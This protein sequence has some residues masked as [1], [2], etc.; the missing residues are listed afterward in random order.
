MP[1]WTTQAAY[2]ENL[3]PIIRP[4]YK[5]SV[6]KMKAHMKTIMKTRYTRDIVVYPEFYERISW[7]NNKDKIHR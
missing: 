5:I 1:G 7:T 2:I 4:S 3:V 6:K